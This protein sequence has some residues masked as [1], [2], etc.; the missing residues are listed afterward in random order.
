METP[1]ISQTVVLGGAKTRALAFFTG[2]SLARTEH[3]VALWPVSSAARGSLVVH[4]RVG[5]GTKT[6]AS[7]AAV[8]AH[9]AIGVVWNSLTIEPS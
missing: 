7:C 9:P 1:P 5:A 8:L 6:A 2:Q 4:A 3:C